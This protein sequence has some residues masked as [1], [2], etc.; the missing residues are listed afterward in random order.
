[1]IINT[2]ILHLLLYILHNFLFSE[3]G[4]CFMAFRD[5]LLILQQKKSRPGITRSLLRK[6]SFISFSA[7]F[8]LS[9]VFVILQSQKSAGH[10][11]FYGSADLI[12]CSAI[13]MNTLAGRDNGISILD[14]RD[15]R[16]GICIIRG[17][18]LYVFYLVSQ[19]LS[20]GR[21]FVDCVYIFIY[22]ADGEGGI[23]TAEIPQ[24]SK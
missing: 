19:R 1:M 9:S 11:A 15:L 10:P 23:K 14:C 5:L 16:E 22:A 20:A 13:C 12:P 4:F 18:V 2:N 3:E 8:S 24:F 21:V 17:F 6:R 7:E